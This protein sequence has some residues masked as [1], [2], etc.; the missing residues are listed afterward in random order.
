LRGEFDE[1]VL[2][3]GKEIR[4]LQ[5]Y[6]KFEEKRALPGSK[7][8]PTLSMASGSFLFFTRSFFN[9]ILIGSMS[10]RLPM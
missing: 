4:I 3:G 10:G 2:N 7:T 9:K 8:C 5:G 1:I 6:I